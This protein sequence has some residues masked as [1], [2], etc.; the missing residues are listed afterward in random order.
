MLL[1]APPPGPVLP[2]EQPGLQ[3]D[4]DEHDVA[5]HDVELD[6]QL[7]RLLLVLV[8]DPAR[9]EDGGMGCGEPEGNGLPEHLPVERLQ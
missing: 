9:L 6:A 3:A 7:E 8:D 2:V 1:G 4:V 5:E